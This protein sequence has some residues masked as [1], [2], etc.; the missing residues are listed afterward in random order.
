MKRQLFL[1]TFNERESKTSFRKS[2]GTEVSTTHMAQ[3][4]KALVDVDNALSIDE[5]REFLERPS[6]DS[7]LTKRTLHVLQLVR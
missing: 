6:N 7:L 3:W 2:V 5:S 1:F 4:L